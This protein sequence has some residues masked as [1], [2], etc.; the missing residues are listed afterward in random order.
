MGKTSYILLTGFLLLFI[1][2][3]ILDLATSIIL[4]ESG[5]GQEVN[6]V[7]RT[8]DGTFNT[9][10]FL[11]LSAAVG[12]VMT[13]L[14]AV[15]IRNARKLDTPGISSR[16]HELKAMQRSGL[17]SASEGAAF[18]R[19]IA[20]HMA[21]LI[22]FVLLGAKILAVANNGITILTGK[23]P[24]AVVKIPEWVSRLGPDR[25]YWIVTNNIIV[26]LS[27]LFALAAHEF[28]VRRLAREWDSA[29]ST[30]K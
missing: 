18:I 21:V 5:A 22:P 27:W 24:I 10:L 14:F 11:A 1:L 25:Y 17:V 7:L 15:G 12:A 23:S 20:I 2:L 28:V 9:S 16:I 29:A 4:T 19:K 3:S 26:A 8:A 6:S 30:E 13:A